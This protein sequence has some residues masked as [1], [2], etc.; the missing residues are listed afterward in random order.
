[1]TLK[2]ESGKNSMAV[3]DGGA[4]ALGR[5]TV[6]QFE[7]PTGFEPVSL[8]GGV[9]EE[10]RQWGV[11]D[12]SSYMAKMERACRALGA[13]GMVPEEAIQQTYAFAEGAWDMFEGKSTPRHNGSHIFAI[14]TFVSSWDDGRYNSEI[15]TCYPIAEYVDSKTLVD[16]VAG[17][18]PLIIDSYPARDGAQGHIL[19]APVMPDL[20]A[21]LGFAGGMRMANQIVN[22]TFRFGRE[23]IGATVGGA[24][25]TLPLAVRLGEGITVEGI[26]P[27]TG[28]AATIE[29]ARQ[30]VRTVVVEKG[31]VPENKIGI[32]GARGSIGRAML[33]IL[34]DEYPNVKFV[35]T[36]LDFADRNSDSLITPN[37]GAFQRDFAE[38]ANRITIVPSA[39]EVLQEAKIVVSAVT[40][41][42]DVSKMAVDLGETV[43]V[44]DSQPTA[45]DR[46][47]F[48][49][50][51]GKMIGVVAEDYTE[52]GRY[53]RIGGFRYGRLG[54][55]GVR[56]QFACESETIAVYEAAREDGVHPKEYATVGRVTN[57]HVPVMGRL[58]TRR[59]IAMARQLQSD[60][61]PVTL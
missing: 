22:D 42:I 55:M 5:P 56:Y 51:G 20:F 6:A 14:P 30:D 54:V 18:P 4:E 57:R 10:P 59:G 58:L 21:D 34:L 8:N 46:E 12:R 38:Y 24:G 36:D 25:A 23:K 43:L 52:D 40:T 15:T 1:L 61:R 53:T 50:K 39:E 41:P 29:I 16:L 47:D 26:Q 13:T 35:I 2:S 9:F 31:G 49:A 27:T 28:H 37:V 45:F 7:V 33:R 19:F 60:G 17:V 11:Y 48:E 3:A 32:V 44:E